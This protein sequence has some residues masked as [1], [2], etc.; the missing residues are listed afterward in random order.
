MGESV[1]AGRSLVRLCRRG[2]AAPCDTPRAACTGLR[3]PGRSKLCPLMACG[4][5]RGGRL[6]G[7][8]S[9]ETARRRTQGAARLKGWEP[10]RERLNRFERLRGSRTSDARVDARET[11]NQ[12][13]F[14]V[15][16]CAQCAHRRTTG[17]SP[18]KL[19]C[20]H[21]EER[22]GRGVLVACNGRGG[23]SVETTTR[24]RG[25]LVAYN[26]RGGKSVEDRSAMEWVSP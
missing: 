26:D 25:V 4:V 5:S 8:V 24:G 19:R 6:A 1:A 11:A 9:R 17:M 3:N 16:G 10:D 13:S 12:R 18:R 2:F 21:A 15:I 14:R 7:R 20:R 22:A 23:T